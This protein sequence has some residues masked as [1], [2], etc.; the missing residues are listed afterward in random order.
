[1]YKSTS[2]IVGLIVL[3]VLA[4]SGFGVYNLYKKQAAKS[5]ESSL[6]PT[7]SPRARFQVSPSPSPEDQI[8]APAIQPETGTNTAQVKNL[9]ITVD[10]PKESAQISSPVKIS[11]FANVLDGRVKIT[12][13]DASDNILGEG[14]ATACF[15]LNA[16]PFVAS[17]PYTHPKTPN[18]TITASA[19]SP[20]ESFTQY[21]III[22]VD[23]K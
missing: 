17:I 22:P 6:G 12:V 9:G 23:F 8:S 15:G 5:L 11:G 2:F 16:C 18:G 10:T 14:L 1:M 7:P 13:K 3:V 4:A 19:V 20:E 21:Q